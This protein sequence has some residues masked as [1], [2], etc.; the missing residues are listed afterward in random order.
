MGGVGVG[1]GGVGVERKECCDD[2]EPWDEEDGPRVWCGEVEAE[3]EVEADL[4]WV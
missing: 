2:C 3:T 4:A 1:V